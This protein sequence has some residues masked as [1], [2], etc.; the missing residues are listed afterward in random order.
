ME[1]NNLEL[2]EMVKKSEKKEISL[3]SKELESLKDQL[4]DMKKEIK[5]SKN[6][7]IKAADERLSELQD[8][9]RT[10]LKEIQTQSMKKPQKLTPGQTVYVA[11]YQKKGIIEEI[12]SD[13][14]KVR[15]GLISVLMDIA[16]IYDTD[17]QPFHDNDKKTSVHYTG[18]SQS[19]SIQIDLRGM[20]GEEAMKVL[21]KNFD[22]ALVDGCSTLFII[23]GKGEGILRKLVWDFLKKNPGVKSYQFAKP[24]EG[25]QGKT[26]VELQ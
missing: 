4:F 23:H 25:G 5:H 17:S 22:A 10:K 1:L 18:P 16:D 12:G 6:L 26:I 15:I 3:L 20:Y 8:S 9:L 19:Y 11:S 24:E 7:D 2:E 13:K 14:V 21:E